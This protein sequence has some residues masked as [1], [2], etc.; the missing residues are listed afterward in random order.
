MEDEDEDGLEIRR[1]IPYDTLVKATILEST[2][3]MFTLTFTLG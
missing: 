1:D 3:R 2:V